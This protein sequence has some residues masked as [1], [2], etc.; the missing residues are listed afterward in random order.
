MIHKPFHLYKRPTTKKGKYVYYVRFYDETG[1]RLPGR[2]TGLSYK[3]AAESWAYEQLKSG[4]VIV[5]KNITF[6]KYAQNWWLW[7]KCD[8]IKGKLA[9]GSSLSRTYADSMRS[10]LENHIL[11]TFK[12]IKLQKINPAMIET[13]LM[14]LREK[15]SKDGVPLSHT[16]INH[17]LKCL[18]VMLKEARRL[19][20]VS[21]NPASEVRRLGEKPRERSILTNEEFYMLFLDPNHDRVWR[22]NFLH[23]CLNLTAALTAMRMGELQ[24]LQVQHV[25]RDHIWIEYSW[26]R[27]YGLK[28]PKWGSKRKAPIN[29]IISVSLQG[30]I[31]RS[32]F[33][34]PE[35]LIFYGVNRKTPVKN[36]TISEKF[37][38]ALEA[39]GITPELRKQRNITFHSHRHFSN[40]LYRGKLPEHQ[41]RLLTGHKSSKMSDHYT[42]LQSEDNK[43]VVD[44]QDEFTD[45]ARLVWDREISLKR[46]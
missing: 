35:D 9:R 8:Y 40:S 46:Q 45:Q 5:Q 21:I 10:Y 3:S 43:A 36:K 39:I 7:D 6:G 26:E 42:H 19:G 13:W 34:D 31:E 4:A 29:K 30:L 14:G 23:Y 28:A 11:P 2:S 20:Y 37:Y 41:L 16:T 24:G 15:E 18:K 44:I 32:P 17:C 1:N 38:A 25:H 22:G 12:D 27:K 33:Q